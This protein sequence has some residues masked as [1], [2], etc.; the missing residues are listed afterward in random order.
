M[1]YYLLS[2]C[3]LLLQLCL[4]KRR[5]KKYNKVV[6]YLIISKNEK[7]PQIYNGK[8]KK[9]HVINNARNIFG[10]RSFRFD[11]CLVHNHLNFLII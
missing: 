11:Y 6:K 4:I 8:Y 10:T 7:N 1:C 2:Y 3:T 5:L 9:C